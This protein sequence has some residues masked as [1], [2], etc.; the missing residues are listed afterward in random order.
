MYP[1]AWQET[2]ADNGH[3][4]AF[5]GAVGNCA[6]FVQPTR[7]LTCERII[8]LTI[9]LTT[10]GLTNYFEDLAQAT[11]ELTLARIISQ[12][13]DLYQV[14]SEQGQ[15][16]AQV[17]GKLNYQLTDPTSYPTVG[18]WVLMT[19][20]S[21]TDQAVIDQV[22]PRQSLLARS[23]AGTGR[24]GQ[25]IAA[26]LTTIFICMALNGDFNVRR[27][28]R[29]L[30][31]AWDSGATPVVV[32]T[33]V[34][35]CPVLDAKMALLA[36]STMGVDVISCSAKTGAGFDAVNAYLLP[37]KTVAFIGSSGVGKSTLINHLLGTE[38][39]LTKTIREDDAK[40][41]HATTA[42]QLIVLPQGG[43]VIDTPGMR[44]L[45]LLSGNFDQSFA[46][47]T[48]LAK[49]CKFRDCQHQGEPGCAVQ[50]AIATGELSAD[51]LASYQKLQ[52]ELAYQGLTARERENA[53]I[54]RLFGGKS[55]MKQVVK[56]VRQKNK[57]R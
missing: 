40:G 33:K 47:V 45:Q 53:K 17:S 52:Q 2:T 3:R 12:H 46:D 49:N 21:T 7:V 38:A 36:D 25:A 34:D 43:L 8:K 32:L 44:E 27:L 4:I 55:A 48:A 56:Q 9:N 6:F 10:Y 54:E 35:L 29:Y 23:A 42:R 5:C 39:L 50:A 57:R 1:Y 30:T 22:L 14:V 28:E 15:Q 11:P 18:D 51:R 37:G 19:A 26:N 31:M 20:T 41:R 16:L 13:R 24:Q